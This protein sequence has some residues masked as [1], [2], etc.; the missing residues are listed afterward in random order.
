MHGSSCERL[1]IRVGKRKI[2]GEPKYNR[3]WWSFSE[4]MIPVSEPPIETLAIEGRPALRSIENLQ[5]SSATRQLFD[6][7]II[8][9]FSCVFV[10][11]FFFILFLGDKNKR[12][13]KLIWEV[14]FSKKRLLKQLCT[15]FKKAHYCCI[16][17]NNS[18]IFCKNVKKIKTNK[19][20]KKMPQ[21]WKKF[22]I[23]FTFLKNV[24]SFS[25]T[26]NSW[27]LW[28]YIFFSNLISRKSIF[29][30][31]IDQKHQKNNKIR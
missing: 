28:A 29:C 26:D 2:Y 3:R 4:L 17:Q 10:S 30:I 23:F 7:Q 19:T 9:L 21:F 18:Q 22:L 12:T 16:L 31:N 5:N 25:W 27:S 1:P 15:P 24:T 20:I 11:W 8:W 13:K 14:E 6:F